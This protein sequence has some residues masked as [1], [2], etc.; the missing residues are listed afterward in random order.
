MSLPSPW[1]C[2][3]VRTLGKQWDKGIPQDAAQVIC[4]QGEE[5]GWLPSACSGGE[6]T[7]Q[8]ICGLVCRT[9]LGNWY[10]P[11]VSL[12]SSVTSDGAGK[13]IMQ[14]PPGLPPLSAQA[15][16]E[17]GNL[18][19]REITHCRV[20]SHSQLAVPMKEPSSFSGTSK[21]ISELVGESEMALDQEDE[22][23]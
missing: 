23:A 8:R 20:C 6:V 4:L 7:R 2:G 14:G 9:C 18:T 12:H 21:S 15:D 19:P 17:W 11:K 1:F 16:T 5:W 13:R 22:V 10:L 3:A